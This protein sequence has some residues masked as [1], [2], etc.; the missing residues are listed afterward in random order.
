[1]STPPRV[2]KPA[3]QLPTGRYPASRATVWV[4]TVLVAATCVVLALGIP[5]R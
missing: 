5:A 2:H 3:T 1:M 4:V